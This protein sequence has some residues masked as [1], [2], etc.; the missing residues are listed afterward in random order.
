MFESVATT[1]LSESCRVTSSVIRQRAQRNRLKVAV[2]LFKR[3]LL[4]TQH[5]AGNSQ[6]DQLMATTLG[7]RLFEL[8]DTRTWASWFES[9]SPVPKRRT[10]RALDE[11][12]REGIRV[13]FP[14][15]DAQF[16]LAPG[17]FE[18]L[19]H[20]GLVS[21]MGKVSSSKRAS[22]ALSD[23]VARYEPLSA[24]HMHMDS[25]EIAALAEGMGDLDWA[26]VKALGAKRLMSILYRLWG[27]RAGAIYQ[28]FASDLRLEWNAATADE[29]LLLSSRRPIFPISNFTSLMREVP[30][31]KWSSIGV[32][33][34]VAEVHIH[35]TMLALAGDVEF[36]KGER[37][38]AW[39]FDLA[40]AALAMHALAWADRYS[41]FGIRIEGEQICW[42]TFSW[43]FFALS[44][45]SEDTRNVEATM[46]YLGL[47]WSGQLEQ[48]L[49]DG[50]ASYLR[51]LNNLG[52]NVD[53]LVSVARHATDV[54]RLIYQA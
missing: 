29:R 44:E 53:D 28:L 50:R 9:S 46:S 18:E 42:W 24:W 30:V 54:H 35:K 49:R 52:L 2:N 31:P 15:G 11:I 1:A 8:L 13:V 34:D 4:G 38:T 6:V 16:V 27:P 21:S 19:V 40:S 33:E 14:A 5:V 3:Y 12:A 47:P 37:Q 25:M 48:V 23:A 41:T 20:G 7:S 22:A 45:P 51:E 43:M 32:E 10:V 39:A 17:F 36:L 26:Y